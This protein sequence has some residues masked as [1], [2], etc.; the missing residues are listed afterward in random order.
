MAWTDIERCWRTTDGEIF[1]NPDEAEEHQNELDMKRYLDEF[2]E[3]M[4]PEIEKMLEP[5][6]KYIENQTESK[7]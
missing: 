5:L 6:K 7:E 3:G 2:K 1:T 4:K